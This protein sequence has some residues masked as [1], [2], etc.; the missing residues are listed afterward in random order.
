MIKK[1]S[2]WYDKTRIYSIEFCLHMLADVLGELN[3]LNKTFQEE[4]VDITTIG[5]DLEVTICTLSRWFFRKETFAEDTTYLSKFLCDS[6][7]GYVEIKDEGII[8]HRHELRYISI[9]TREID[10]SDRKQAMKPHFE[11]TQESC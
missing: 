7:Y 4:N 6:Q 8:K 10:Y 11:G 3:K 2:S 9:P 1:N 5:L